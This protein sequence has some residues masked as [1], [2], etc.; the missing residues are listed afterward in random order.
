MPADKAYA[1]RDVTATVESVPLISASIMSKK[2]AEGSTALLLDVKCGDGAFMKS[3]SDARAL[4]TSMVA[5]GVH[6]GVRIEAVI[7]DMD[8]P[9]GRTVGNALEIREC[10]DLLRGGGPADLAALV[11]RLAARMAVLGGQQPDEASALRAVTAAL[12]SGAALDTFRR[13]V[14]QQGGD[15]R[16]VDDPGLLPS[17]PSVATVRAPRAGTA[18]GDPGRRDRTGQPRSRRRTIGRR[19]G[20]RPRG[21]RPAAQDRGDAVKAGDEL[22][23]LHHRDARGSTPRRRSVAPPSSSPT[24]ARRPTTASSASEMTETTR[25]AP[26]QAWTR[27]DAIVLAGLAGVAAVA[28]VLGTLGDAPAADWGMASSW[29]SPIACRRRGTPSTTAPWAGGSGCSSCSRWWC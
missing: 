16:V 4:A 24:R 11:T 12:G 10:L 29:P 22:V 21:R 25:A 18:D 3:E 28:I 1:L 2:L 9:L 17:A 5:I 19:R 8:A 20:D 14:R 23:E 15:P 6:A 26:V 13:M 7:T 27:H